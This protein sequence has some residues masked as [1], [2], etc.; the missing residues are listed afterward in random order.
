MAE[1]GSL[2]VDH[3]Y[4]RVVESW[5]P[6]LFRNE[7]SKSKTSDAGG[8]KS[9]VGKNRSEFES[10]SLD[11]STLK[12]QKKKKQTVP[13]ATKIGSLVEGKIL[14]KLKK[15]PQQ[16]NQL[17]GNPGNR[18]ATADPD[19]SEDQD[20][21][22]KSLSQQKQLINPQQQ[23]GGQKMSRS[24]ARRLKRRQKKAMEQQAAGTQEWSPSKLSQG[25]GEG[26]KQNKDKDKKNNGPK[27]SPSHA[28][29]NIKVD[30][31]SQ[32]Q[33]AGN[34]EKESIS[35]TNS[36]GMKDSTGKKASTPSTQVGQ[37]EPQTPGKTVNGGDMSSPVSK[38]K[39]IKKQQQSQEQSVTESPKS[40]KQTP[41]KQLDSDLKLSSP[42]AEAKSNQATTPSPVSKNKRKIV[43]ATPEHPLS[44]LP[45]SPKQD[46]AA[47]NKTTDAL[48]K[49]DLKQVEVTQDE[50]CT[51]SK[52]RRRRRRSK[53][54][55]PPSKDLAESKEDTADSKNPMNVIQVN[56]FISPTG[57]G[58]QVGNLEG[59]VS[60]PG[61]GKKK[62]K[63]RKTKKVVTPEEQKP[64]EPVEP[65]PKKPK[66]QHQ[67]DLSGGAA[68]QALDKQKSSVSAV[69][70]T[71]QETSPT[72]KAKKKRKNS[73]VLEQGSGKKTVEEDIVSS[74]EVTPA[75]KQRLSVEENEADTGAQPTGALKRRRRARGKRKRTTSEQ[76][77][78][79]E[80]GASTT[81]KSG[82]EEGA[83]VS[84][85]KL[86]IIL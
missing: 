79:S 16:Q 67:P 56:L 53:S 42:N 14:P 9:D 48:L 69:S 26:S 66:L 84:S 71:G 81:V 28:V 35:P 34:K 33:K 54:K 50:S 43:Q 44:D 11:K 12:P 20:S 38:K 2:Q 13:M 55:E 6:D 58:E 83:T 3:S 60:T 76:S 31:P 21:K 41:E 47:S 30:T 18:M 46:S 5:F 49:G 15:R 4:K 63:Q 85:A 73:L 1:V 24:Q 62:R 10:A 72:K 64:H 59:E 37:M 32:K 51:I 8:R 25:K 36:W 57:N 70:L 75:K 80:T 40:S 45:V 68:K 19:E 65:S 29:V 74:T 17:K 23:Q 78:S 52:K 77:Q 82:S 39:K 22:L 27:Q 86:E 61:D 7:Q